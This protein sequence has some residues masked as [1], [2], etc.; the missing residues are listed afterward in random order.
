VGR[1]PVVVNVGVMKG[2]VVTTACELVH[3]DIDADGAAAA[4]ICRRQEKRLWFRL[5]PKAVPY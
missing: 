3:A 1:L 4:A 5:W 2:L